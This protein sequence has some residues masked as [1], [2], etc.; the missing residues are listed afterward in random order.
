MV[1]VLSLIIVL[2]YNFI[3]MNG[4]EKVVSNSPVWAP[5]KLR[6]A[7]ISAAIGVWSHVFLDSI[8]HADMIP[9]RPFSDLNPSLHIIS[10]LTL[11]VICLAGF[12]VAAVIYGLR[13]LVQLVLK[14]KTFGVHGAR[15]WRRVL[16]R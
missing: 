13:Q 16:H 10:V 15:F 5:F 7:L 1:I 4:L 8:M 3:F 2:T 12:I 11:H 14:S 6:Q 9:L